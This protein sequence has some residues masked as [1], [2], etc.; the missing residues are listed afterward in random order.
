MLFRSAPQYWSN[1]VNQ[2]PIDNMVDQP[3]WQNQ[4]INGLK[5]H[6]CTYVIDEDTSHRY[7]WFAAEED[8]ALFVVRWS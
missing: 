5:E 2:Q 7:L 6:N 3:S 8:A 1:F 4:I